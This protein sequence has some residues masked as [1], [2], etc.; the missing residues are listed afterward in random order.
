MKT[1]ILNYIKNHPD[2]IGGFFIG[3]F[4]GSILSKIVAWIPL[5]GP[6]LAFALTLG[7]GVAGVYGV[8]WLK[9]RGREGR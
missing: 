1:M 3:A 6:L 2:L 7:F 8:I 9:A 5:L 4:I